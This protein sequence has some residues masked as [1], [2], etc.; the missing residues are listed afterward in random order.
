MRKNFKLMKDNCLSYYIYVFILPAKSVIFRAHNPTPLAYATLCHQPILFQNGRWGVS[1]PYF[2]L[3]LYNVRTTFFNN[4]KSSKLQAQVQFGTSI[5]HELIDTQ[6][7]N[8]YSNIVEIQF[9]WLSVS[10]FYICLFIN[11]WLWRCYK[12]ASSIILHYRTAIQQKID[13]YNFA[14]KERLQSQ[15]Q[16]KHK[17]KTQEKK[18]E[19]HVSKISLL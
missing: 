11:L 5:V 6:N 17:M 2:F 14:T 12:P 3:V 4:Y 16:K 10:H 8:S 1:L 13:K 7:V 19:K 18:S 15:P 9:A